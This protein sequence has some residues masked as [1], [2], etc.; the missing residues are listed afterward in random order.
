MQGK[1]RGFTVVELMVTL[2]VVAIVLAFAIPG[3]QSV[4]NDNRLSSASN[5]LIANLQ[6]ARMEAIRRGRRV[7]VCA[8]ANP[9]AGAG[10]TCAT[11][12]V[13]GWITFVDEDTD[14]DFGA[15]DKLLR[16]AS[17]DAMVEITGNT[18]FDFRADGLAR[19]GAGTLITGDHLRLR[20]DTT[21]PARNVRCVDVT[22]A[23]ASVSKPA[24]HDAACT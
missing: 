22:V 3:F 15:G 5:E 1:A 10:A 7:V 13:H 23:G 14:G 2:A 6:T 12:G 17:F 8:S 21:Q 18:V 24:T 11:A 4:I 20:I 16:N 19:D 9:N